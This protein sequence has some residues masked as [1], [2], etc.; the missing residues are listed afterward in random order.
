M[1]CECGMYATTEECYN[2]NPKW[3]ASQILCLKKEEVILL[4]EHLKHEYMTH[5]EP[6]RSLLVKIYQFANE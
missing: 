2:C 6:I 3:D 1:S 5:E 4:S